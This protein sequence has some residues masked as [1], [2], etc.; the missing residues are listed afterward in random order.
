MP[1]IFT[2]KYRILT[3]LIVT[4]LAHA[5]SDA[6]N[7]VPKPKAY[8]RINFVEKDYIQFKNFNGCNYSFLIPSYSA[9]TPDEANLNEKCWLNIN[10]PKYGGTL[11]I[12]YFKITNRNQIIKLS[13]DSRKLVFKHTIKAS[14]INEVYL[15]YPKNNVYGF[16]YEIEGNAASPLQFYISDN[17]SN[18]LRGSLYFNM[19][20]NIDF[21]KPVID[22]IRIDINK[23]IESLRWNPNF[24]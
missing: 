10:Y 11:H 14:E 24:N 21:I 22:Y 18:F 4:F 23:L 13:E 7:S 5:C 9:V 17:K 20:P 3:L 8:Y 16:L 12:S 15:S 1:K 6:P 19:T 2:L